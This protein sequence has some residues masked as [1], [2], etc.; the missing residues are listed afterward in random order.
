MLPFYVRPGDPPARRAIL[1]ESLRLFS[2]QGLAATTV[3]DIA[4]RTG[5]TNP[6]LYR[7]FASKDALALYL[8]ESAHLRLHDRIADAV[9]AARLPDARL[10]AYWSCVLHLMDESPEAFAFLHDHAAELFPRASAAIRRRSLLVQARRIAWQCLPASAHGRRRRAEFAA[11]AFI[12]T[13]GQLSRALT[14]GVL[15]RP[16]VAWLDDTV[17]MSR[18][19]LALP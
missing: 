9:R 14:L 2:E 12:G 16:A 6:A 1:V 17:D 8:F 19:M 15:R 5:Y 4:A 7:H 11:H 13:A 3:R 18:R 10:R